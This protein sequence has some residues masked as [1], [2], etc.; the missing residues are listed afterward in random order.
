MDSRYIR[1]S[2]GGEKGGKKKGP[3]YSLL[4]GGKGKRGARASRQRFTLSR[5]S[6]LREKKEKEAA[7]VLSIEE[8]KGGKEGALIA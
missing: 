8:D 4:W 1:T 6:Q 3:R 2:K 7:V 5:S